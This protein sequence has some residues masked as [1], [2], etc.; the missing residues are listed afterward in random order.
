MKLLIGCGKM[1]G[2][3]LKGWIRNEVS[4]IVV[5]AQNEESALKITSEYEVE[6]VTT[7]EQLQEKTE[8]VLVAVKPYQ[9]VKVLPQLK[10][11]QDSVIVSVMAGITMESIME[12]SGGNRNVVR[13][14][15]NLTC[16]LGEG[17]IGAYAEIENKKIVEDL[18]S[19][20]GKVFWLQDEREIEIT[21]ALPSGMP[22]FLMKLLDMYSKSIADINY[23]DE[24]II[25]S[26]LLKLFFSEVSQPILEQV[27]NGWISDAIIL[28]L[29]EFTANEMAHRTIFGTKEL[30]KNGMNSKE[31]IESVT[32]KGGTTE[33]GLLAME[34]GLSPI[35]AA[36]R[37]ALEIGKEI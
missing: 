17:V 9:A 8:V 22:A 19:V 21:A 32:S 7:V 34:H 25:E 1:G 31:I 10:K 5:L 2:A 23:S 37:R 11:C 3:I 16:L 35:T 36:Y 20:V 15:P 30:L 26:K 6:A 13:A 14:M 33:A 12:M 28:G 4:D 27:E 24:K 18:L 29:D